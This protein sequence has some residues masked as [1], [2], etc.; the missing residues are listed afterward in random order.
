MKRAVWLLQA[1][2]LILLSLPLAIMPHRFSQKGGE[3]LGLLLFSLWRSRRLVALDNLK[4]AVSAGGLRITD[5]AHNV[6]RGYFKNLGRS[7]AEIIKL[8]WGFGKKIVDTVSFEGIEH[9]L[10]AQ[11]KNRGVLFITGHCGNWELL[12][13]AMS[14]KF[15][16]LAIVARPVDNPYI[17]NMVEA[18]RKRYGNRVIYKKGALRNIMQHLKKNMAVGILMDQAV[19]AEEGYIIDFL[20]SGAWTTKIPALIA[21]KTGAAVLPAFIS[22][23]DKGHHIQIFPEISLSEQNDKEKAV[24]EDTQAF[25][26]Y[27]E[28]YIRLHP[29]EWL[30]I[31]KR[32]KRVR[33]NEKGE[34]VPSHPRYS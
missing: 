10:N 25:S 33:M 30:W 31:H 5:T 24:R 34:Y 18:T 14:A 21:R 16:D 23:T 15:S 7:S 19:I 2:L 9:F 1:C 20:G 13:I 4:N 6:I 8:H 32:W 17:N 22:R 11:S 26:R 27:I 29:D 28:Q 12:A 3:L